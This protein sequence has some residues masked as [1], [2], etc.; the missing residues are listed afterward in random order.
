LPVSRGFFVFAVEA[1]GSHGHNPK[2]P[3]KKIET[4][5]KI[6]TQFARE[7]RF[8]VQSAPAA[9]FRAEQESGL[10]Q[11]KGRLL[12]QALQEAVDPE[13]YAPLRRAA[14]EAAALAWATTY[15]LLLFPTL[16]EEKAQA[17]VVQALRQ[18]ELRYRSLAWL[19]TAV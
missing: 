5:R 13:F 9:P 3:M 19:D 8:A 14:N 16:F 18:A 17:A 6:K 15:P 4:N 1:W 10:E 12:Q 2:E 11:L 7:T